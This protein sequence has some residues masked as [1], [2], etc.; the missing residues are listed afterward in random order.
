M[1]YIALYRRWRPDSFDSLV[2]QQHISQTLSRAITTG[3]IAHAYL[4]TG[5]RGT[6]KT[7]T[8]KILAKALNCERGISPS[9]CGVCESCKD[10]SDGS[11]MEVFEID[12]ASNRGIDEI[13]E[14]RETVKFPPLAGHHRVY[15]IDE[16]HMLTTEAF[17]ALLKT[18]EEPPARVI[19]ILATTEPQKVPATIQSRC[20]RYDFRRITSEDIVARLAYV[21]GEMN[22]SAE[23]QALKLIALQADGG[24][25]DALSILDRCYALSDGYV[26]EELVRTTLG[27]VGQT[28]IQELTYKIAEGQAHEALILLADGIAGGKELNQ[29]AMEFALYFRSLMIYQA[30]GMVNGLEIY[31]TDEDKLKA[32]SKQFSHGEIVAAI[33]KINEALRELKWSA[34]PRLTLESLVMTL[35]SRSQST[36]EIPAIVKPA[37]KT[38]PAAVPKATRTAS[39]SSAEKIAELTPGS[40]VQAADEPTTTGI[41]TE[42][43]AP[44]TA[45]SEVNSSERLTA[46]IDGAAIWKK[47]LS[48]TQQKYRMSY[49]AL[50][51]AS[52]SKLT[53][54][55]LHLTTKNATIGN[56]IMGGTRARSEECLTEIVGRP[57]KIVCHVVS[58]AKKE[59]PPQENATNYTNP[60]YPPSVNKLL[61]MTGGAAIV[62]EVEK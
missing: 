29:I 48:L 56:I 11:S 1:S 3:R 37:A 24:L 13:R 22:I 25:R 39:K 60:D 15:I 7:S 51:V 2:G 20:Q 40:A 14:L 18:I 61:E 35:A 59:N 6:G 57:M 32:L 27:M 52:F 12:A 58:D 9:P 31:A 54:S 53:G 23:P 28:W 10:I 33:Q 5:P 21:A 34:L 62:E 46:E 41:A 44:E 47:L 19:F 26:T 36:D 49:A 4:F 38:A 45:V 42:S 43:S 17:N 8:A 55:E 16:V 50:C 30:A